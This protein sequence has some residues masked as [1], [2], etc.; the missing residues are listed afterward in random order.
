MGE[1]IIVINGVSYLIPDNKIQELEEWLKANCTGAA[2][3]PAQER[4]AT[5]CKQLREAE[6][7]LAKAKKAMHLQE[8]QIQQD[9][10]IMKRLEAER[11]KALRVVYELKAEQ[12][13]LKAKRDELLEAVK[14][15]GDKRNYD[16][17]NP[18]KLWSSVHMDA[19]KRARD[20]VA[21]E[22]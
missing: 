15:Y 3:E 9:R 14:W 11:D 20:A 2:S 1:Q 7:G 5:L 6:T 19:G 8:M 16:V 12:K 18:Q 10:P 22:G 21:S 17:F 13:G 4:V